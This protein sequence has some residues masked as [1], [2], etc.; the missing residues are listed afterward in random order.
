MRTAERLVTHYGS[1]RLAA[2]VLGVTVETIR[3][4]LKNGIPPNSALD[5]EHRTNRLITAEEVIQEERQRR[6]LLAAGGGGIKGGKQVS[7]ATA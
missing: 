1:R 7:E 3:L 6:K 2:D 5:V 4:W